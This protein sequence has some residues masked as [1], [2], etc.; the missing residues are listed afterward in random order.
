MAL[1]QQKVIKYESIFL[2]RFQQCQVRTFAQNNLMIAATS[3]TRRMVFISA[4]ARA[5]YVI[6]GC[7]DYVQ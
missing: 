1:N 2:L 7:M 4:R 6:S 3:Q 5:L